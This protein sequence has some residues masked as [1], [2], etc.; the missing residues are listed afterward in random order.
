MFVYLNFYVKENS[1]S[2]LSSNG[3]TNKKYNFKEMKRY[4]QQNSDTKGNENNI[5]YICLRDSAVLTSSHHP[6]ATGSF[7]LPVKETKYYLI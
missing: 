6:I 4:V 5:Q 3:G 2:Q 1:Y 7:N